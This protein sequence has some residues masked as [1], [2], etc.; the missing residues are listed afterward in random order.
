ME[1]HEVAAAARALVS[2]GYVHRGDLGLTDREAFTSPD[3]DPRRHVYVCVRGTL[4]VRRH[5]AVRDALRGS[6]EL[7]DRYARVKID[8]AADPDIGIARYIVGKSAVLQEVLMASDLTPAE[9]R[10]IYEVNTSQEP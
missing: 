2:I 6:A 4:H 5:L 7:R 10:E 9:K 1:R 3:H 8:L